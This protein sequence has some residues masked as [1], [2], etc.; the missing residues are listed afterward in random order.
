[1]VGMKPTDI[2][3]SIAYSTLSTMPA[4]QI[5]YLVCQ[6]TPGLTIGS[7]TEIGGECYQ[8]LK[9][10]YRAVPAGKSKAIVS[11]E[12]AVVQKTY[13]GRLLLVLELRL[14]QCCDCVLCVSF[15]RY[16]MSICVFIVSKVVSYRNY[17]LRCAA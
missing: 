10:Q 14:G 17:S 3:L 4:N 13:R 9:A 16:Y 11:S 8:T 5:E 15:V 6:M 12:L 1:M 2:D 7:I